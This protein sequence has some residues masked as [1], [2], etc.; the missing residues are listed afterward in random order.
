MLDRVAMTIPVDVTNT[1]SD[2]AREAIYRADRTAMPSQSADWSS[3]IVGD[4]WFVDAS[5]C[6]RFAD[7]ISAYLPLYRS[8]LGPDLLSVFSSPPPAWGF[9]GLVSDAPLT[10]RHLRTVLNDL[11]QLSGAAVKIRPNPLHGD[12]WSEAAVG[13]RWTP[14]LRNAHVLDLSGGYDAVWTDKFPG[15]TRSKI[16]RAGKAS[17]TIVSGRNEDLISDFDGLFRQ[18]VQRWAGKQNEFAWL[19]G[20][21]AKV[22]DPKAKFRAFAQNTGGLVTF[23]LAYRNDQPVAGIMVLM[24]R[25]AHYTRGAMDKRLIGNTYANHL[26]HASAIEAACK[27]GCRHYHMGETGSSTSLAQFKSSFGAE[28]RPY[29]EYVHER[30]PLLS[31]D[32]KLRAVVKKAIGFRDA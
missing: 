7:G 26:L 8:R 29:A 27:A 9:G 22:R 14:V 19:A 2:T 17:I 32:R 4:G 31:A 12:L 30:I 11:E 25:N 13:T 18:S 21:R 5:R 20:L 16:R 10:A 3:S 15:K 23:W 28:S 24:D 6:Y 1:I